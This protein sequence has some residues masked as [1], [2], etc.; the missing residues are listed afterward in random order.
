MSTDKPKVVKIDKKRSYVTNLEKGYKFK[1]RSSK[2]ALA[3]AENNQMARFTETEAAIFCRM[4]YLEPFDPYHEVTVNDSLIKAKIT[5]DE[6]ND[7]L[8]LKA[9]TG[10]KGTRFVWPYSMRKVPKNVKSLED[11][12]DEEKKKVEGL[13]AELDALRAK[14]KEAKEAK[15]DKNQGNKP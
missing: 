15:T 1:V 4:N 3:A 12:L 11:E 7:I 6:L 9:G 8:K 2:T 10:S 5:G 14:K 13:Q